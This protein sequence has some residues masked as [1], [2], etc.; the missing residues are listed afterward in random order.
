MANGKKTDMSFREAFR[1]ARNRGQKT[2][3]WRGKSF[4][5]KLRNGVDKRE[6]VVQ[7]SYKYLDAFD[8]VAMSDPMNVP[9]GLLGFIG[10]K[11]K[12]DR[13]NYNLLS[14]EEYKYDKASEEHLYI[15]E[16]KEK[17]G[18]GWINM[19]NN[20]QKLKENIMGYKNA[21]GSMNKGTDPY[22][23]FVNSAVYGNGH[24][25]MH[26]DGDGNFHFLMSEV[27]IKDKKAKEK[28]IETGEWNEEYADVISLN[29]MGNYSIIQEPF[30]TKNFVFKLADQ[31]KI[32]KDSG[33]SFDENF[34]YNAAL[35]NFND[36]GP[37]DTIGAAF[38]DLAG[39]GITKSFAEMYDEEFLNEE[40][41]IDPETGQRLPK[42]LE[43]MRDPA[44]AKMLAGLLARY[45]TNVMKD[46]HGPTIDVKTG[47]VK[48]S[49]SQLAQEII[50]KYS[51]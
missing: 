31:T 14:N 9:S 18:R 5:T 17:I 45:I 24:D 35:N 30:V 13:A 32:N 15:K 21:L 6:F 28:F 12:K 2:F 49:Q 8:E 22:N 41:Y 36:A 47:Q 38:A 34:V 48:K 46:I 4:N 20:K 44:N 51:K 42:G 37:K 23:L 1:A 16:Q 25:G 10:N 29:D 7:N 19:N 27:E 11:L 33:K 43:W 3:T 26:I 39:D 50:E 40:Y